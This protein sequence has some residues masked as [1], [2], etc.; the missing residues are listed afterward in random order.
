M[1]LAMSFSINVDNFWELTQTN[2]SKRTSS[3]RGEKTNQIVKSDTYDT[4]ICFP[5]F[6]SKEPTPR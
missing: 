4:V 2:V 3:E 5:R 6:G 1:P